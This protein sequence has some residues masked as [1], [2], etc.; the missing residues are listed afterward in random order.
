MSSDTKYNLGDIL[1]WKDDSKI[2][3]GE[4]TCIKIVVS[5][6]QNQPVYAMRKLKGDNKFYWVEEDKLSLVKE[7]QDVVDNS[8]NLQPEA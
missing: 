1:N 4:V 3:E 2:M 8:E 5:K 7:N 6:E